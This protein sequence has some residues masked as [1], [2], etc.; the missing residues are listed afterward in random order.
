VRAP[1]PGTS[2]RWGKNRLSLN[3]LREPVPVL[4]KLLFYTCFVKFYSWQFFAVFRILLFTL[5]RIRIWL[6]YLVRI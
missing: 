1:R 5:L 6:V 4:K 3:L 2:S